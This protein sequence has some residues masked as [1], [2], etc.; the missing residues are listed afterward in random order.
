MGTGYS[1]ESISWLSYY[2]T[3]LFGCGKANSNAVFMVLQL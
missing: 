1:E 2:S 3:T